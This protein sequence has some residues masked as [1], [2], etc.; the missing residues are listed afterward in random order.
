MK[1]SLNW[2]ELQKY[3]VMMAF[4]VSPL[5]VFLAKHPIV[6]K[7]DQYDQDQKYQEQNKVIG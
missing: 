3:R 4:M 6:D 2:N 1:I 7:Y 5:M